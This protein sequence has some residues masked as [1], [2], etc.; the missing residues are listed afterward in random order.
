MDEI[1]TASPCPSC[2]GRGLAFR[3]AAV[4]CRSCLGLGQKLVPK[5]EPAKILP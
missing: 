4:P 1:L 3:N 5:L 2:D